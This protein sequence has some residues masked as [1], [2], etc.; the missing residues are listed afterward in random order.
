MLYSLLILQL[1]AG[2]L[3]LSRNAKVKEMI[4][5]LKENANLYTTII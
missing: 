1:I 5:A 4:G 3:A 2:S